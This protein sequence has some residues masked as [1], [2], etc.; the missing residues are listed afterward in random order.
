[1]C[2]LVKLRAAD[3]DWSSD[4]WACDTA[5]DL[6]LATI[7][8]MQQQSYKNSGEFER[9]WFQV[10]GVVNLAAKCFSE[11]NRVYAS[12]LA[13]LVNLMDVLPELVEHSWE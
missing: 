1:M 5:I 3:A 9:D 6:A 10:A 8:R 4:D 11:R 12:T 7:Q 13:S 2:S